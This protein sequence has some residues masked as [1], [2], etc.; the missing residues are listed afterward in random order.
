MVAISNLKQKHYLELYQEVDNFLEFAND[1]A[2]AVGKEGK[3]KWE[4]VNHT[5]Y[6]NALNMK[7][8]LIDKINI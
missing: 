5:D 1:Q 4:V 3:Q 7:K 2:K 6:L 8:E